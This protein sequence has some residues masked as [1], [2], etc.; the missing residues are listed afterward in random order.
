MEEVKEKK[1]AVC[2][3]M[4]ITTKRLVARIGLRLLI[5]LLFVLFMMLLGPI[6]KYTLPFVVAFLMANYILMPIIRKLSGKDDNMRK[7]WS[8]VLVVIML[9]LVVGVLVG[10]LYY[11]IVEIVDVVKNWNKYSVFLD[12]TI[13]NIC[14]FVSAHTPLSFGQVNDAIYNIYDKAVI[15][16]KTDLPGQT[17]AILN[18]I[19]KYVPTIGSVFIGFLFFIMAVYFTCAD[20][21]NIKSTIKSFIPDGVR[22]YLRTIKN[23]AGSA[24]FGYL[25]AQLILA[26]IVAVINAIVLLIARQNHALLIAVLVAAV[27][28]IPMLGAG[29]VLWPWAIVC[30]ILGDI[31][32]GIVLIALSMG[33]FL[34]RRIVEPKVVG[35]QTGLHPLVSLLSLYIGIRFGGILGLVIAPIIC[36]MLIGLYKA[37]FFTPTVMDIRLICHRMAR[38]T[39]M[40]RED[41]N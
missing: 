29:I 19:S 25:K 31:P 7:F 18:K 10:A 38:Y 12:N 13:V 34:F 6:L 37:D 36:M 33:L 24:T 20:F 5:I 1:K 9:A 35:D 30:I 28:F 32:K 2:Y 3:D 21:T 41:D 40:T 23:A 4:T 26:G 39:G 22:P 27:D 17:P 11:I 16:A 8:I 14:K 15:W